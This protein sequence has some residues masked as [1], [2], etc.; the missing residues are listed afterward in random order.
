MIIND[1]SKKNDALDPV[2][3]PELIFGLIGPVGTDTQKI[4]SLL[5]SEL[6]NYDYKAY[7]ISVSNCIHK[8]GNLAKLN[9]IKN[10]EYQR[11][12]SHM[13]AGTQIRD[14]SERGDAL[15]L[16]AI[17]EIKDI[18]TEAN[19]NENKE[20]P[21]NI[22]IKRAAYIL[23]SLKH[24]SEIESLRIIYRRAFFAISIYTPRSQ[25]LKALS[26]RIAVSRTD[27]AITD[28]CQPQAEELIHIDENESGTQFGQNVRGAFPK[29]DF[30][31]DASHPQNLQKHL[32]RFLQLVFG[33]PF[34]TPEIDEWGMFYAESS[35]WRSGDLARQVGASIISKEGELLVTGC[36]EVPKAFGGYFW[37]GDNFDDRDLIYGF[38]KGTLHKQLMVA[39]LLKKIGDMGYIDPEKKEKFKEELENTKKGRVGKWLKDTQAYNILEFSRSVHAEMA[40]ISEAAKRGISINKKILY[41]NT[42]PCHICARHILAS[43]IHEVVYIEPY[44]KSLTD[45]LYSNQ[46]DTSGEAHKENKVKFRPFCGVAPRAYQFLF[47]N[48]TERKLQSGYVYQWSKRE[49][50]PKFNQYVASYILL[51]DDVLRYNVDHITNKT[52]YL[53]W[54]ENQKKVTTKEEKGEDNERTSKKVAKSD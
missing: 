23:D 48:I 53:S 10:D 47:C 11:I 41:V 38:D 24:P 46:I 3:A 17:S 14:T 13:K 39:E 50:D 28:D 51:E 21:S 52:K 12:S 27:I 1:N 36:N 54:D 29:A 22:P 18:R 32:D 45:I 34:K 31:L 40:A 8:M 7:R 30:F 20:Y 15:A 44:P 49:A 9:E 19:K 33:N 37:D 25:R 16:L 4:Y 35:S 2:E 6:L 26:E 42:F 5:E 43:G